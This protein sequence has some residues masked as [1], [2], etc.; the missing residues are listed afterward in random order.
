MTKRT[1]DHKGHWRSK[2]VAFRISPEEAQSLDMMVAASGM[3]KQEYL[4]AKAL[5]RTIMVRP[6]VRVQKHIIDCLDDLTSELKRHEQ[7]E[8]DSYTLEDIRHL[9]DLI[10]RMGGSDRPN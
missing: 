4:A 10:S 5:D 3:L 7:I 6:N 9:L 1:N 2:T 8:K